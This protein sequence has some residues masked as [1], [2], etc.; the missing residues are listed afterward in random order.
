[1]RTLFAS[2]GRPEIDGADRRQTWLEL[3]ALEQVY[4]CCISLAGPA[5]AQ[6]RQK[7]EPAVVV[8]DICAEPSFD[9]LRRPPVGAP[10]STSSA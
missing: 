4:L 2:G 10:N 5:T 8:E 9:R 3:Q 6:D 1:M 7:H